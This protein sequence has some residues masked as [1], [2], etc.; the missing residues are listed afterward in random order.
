M[1]ESKIAAITL[2]TQAA[3]HC[4][5]DTRLQR[6]VP[7]LLVCHADIQTGLSL[8]SNRPICCCYRHCFCCCL[9]SCYA[10]LPLLL[11]LPALADHL[12]LV[13]LLASAP[14]H[15]NHYFHHQH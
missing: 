4:D 11:L 6:I 1:Q 14:A 12:L 5:D 3:M 7:Y 9:C 15:C 10:A 8:N 13:S 2:L